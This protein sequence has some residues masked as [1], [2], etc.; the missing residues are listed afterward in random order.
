MNFWLI[1][2]Q[3]FSLTLGC[4]N[5]IPNVFQTFPDH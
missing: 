3:K 4:L 1:M 2:K 5:E